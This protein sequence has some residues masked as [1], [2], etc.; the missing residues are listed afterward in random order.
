MENHL[1][2]REIN[3]T[4][5]SLMDT[6]LMVPT[7]SEIHNFKPLLIV[8]WTLA[9]EWLFYGLFF[10]IILCKVK[11]KILFL[12]G[13]I[14]LLI[15]IG[16]TFHPNNLRLQF[17]TNPIMLEFVLGI[18]ICQM[19]LSLKKIPVW[20]GVT[21]LTLG[22]ISYMLLI[23]FGYGDVWYYQDAISGQVSLQKFLLWG[24]PSSC[25]V[26]GCVFLEINGRIKGLWNNKWAL[27]GGDASYSI[28]LIHY[29]VFELLMLLYKK[30]GPPLPLDLLIWVQM[31]IAVLISLGF[32]KLV[33][34]PLLRYVN[35]INLWKIS[36]STTPE[37]IIPKTK[38]TL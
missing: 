34:R 21:C 16:Q 23:R 31:I 35:K 11:R 17:I 22:L 36:I 32:Y 1:F 3:Q 8:G 27:L 20:I 37:N 13:L 7:A 26:A 4:I 33:E 9:F 30:T 5:N 19:Y 18:I 14:L 2:T 10:I 25:I 6:I 28:Y 24:L 38:P 29:T 12:P 15:S